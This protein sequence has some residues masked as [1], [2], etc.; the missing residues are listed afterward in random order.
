LWQ[1]NFNSGEKRMKIG[2]RVGAVLGASKE[3]TA[4]RLFST[5]VVD[6]TTGCWVWTKGCDWDGYGITSLYKIS[7]RVHRLAYMLISGR[8]LDQEDCVLHHCDTPV[9]FNPDH[10]FLGTAGDNNRD[11]AMKGRNCVG[12]KNGR[13]KLKYNDISAIRVFISEG[14][15]MPQVAKRYGVSTS[16][17]NNI[18]RGVSWK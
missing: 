8:I 12:E 6:P 18:K 4:R 13:A 16:A 9:C 1:A 17:I 15:S 5:K 2:S 3:D 7:F 11:A 14:L 10:L